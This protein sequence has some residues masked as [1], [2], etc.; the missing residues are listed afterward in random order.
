[1]KNS[2]IQKAAS[3]VVVGLGLLAAAPVFA[4]TGAVSGHCADDKGQAIVGYPIVIERQE[5]KGVYKTKTDK[6][7]NYIYMGIPLGQYKV[8]LQD[9]TGK[10]VFFI[11]KH[12]G[13]DPSPT[14]IDFDMAKERAEQAKSIESNP[15]AKKQQELNEKN[16][17]EFAGLHALFEQGQALFEQK[18]YADAAATYEQ[19]LAMTKEGDRNQI[20]VLGRLADTYEK[21]HQ[22]DKAVEDYRKALAATPNDA[23]LHNSLGNALA[24]MGKIPEAQAEF[25]KS[26]E[27][28]PANARMAY[29]NLGVV[30]Y[31]SGHMD[32]AVA[33]F[34]KAAK[35]DPTYADAFYWQGLALMGKATLQGEKVV[36]PEGTVDALQTY[37]KLEPTGKYASA[38][39]QMLQAIQ[40]GV[41]TEYKKTKKK[42]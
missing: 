31:N 2:T 32:D 3:L 37:L 35:A 10:T 13:L 29:F 25:Q 9:P 1:M 28:D 41:Q 7:G 26:A 27:L 36:A 24:E 42:G 33:A 6:K 17:K 14:I 5:V 12:V 39:Q 11:S 8:T 30:M 21:A 16:A 38:A 18:K 22:Y 34:Q 40:G 20:V 19:A 23:P 15:E 4:Q